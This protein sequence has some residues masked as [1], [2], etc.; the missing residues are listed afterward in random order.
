M[1]AAPKIIGGMGTIVYSPIDARHRFTGRTKQIVGGELMG[2]MAGVAICS[3]GPDGFYL[4]GCDQNW[5]NITDT[6]H[7]TLEDAKRQA[8]FEYEGVSGTWR[9]PEE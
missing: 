1:K 9:R 6:W 7:A 4:F 2:P 8:E 5:K 3:S